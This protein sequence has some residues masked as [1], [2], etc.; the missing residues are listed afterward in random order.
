M[1]ALVSDTMKILKLMISIWSKKK[2]V[3]GLKEKGFC[4]A[5]TTCK[6]WKLPQRYAKQETV[7]EFMAKSEEFIHIWSICYFKY[8]EGPRARRELS[9]DCIIFP[10]LSRLRFSL[11]CSAFFFCCLVFFAA[12]FLVEN[13][14]FDETPSQILYVSCACMQEIMFMLSASSVLP[15]E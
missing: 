7:K 15:R 4:A 1:F 12:F 13:Y 5:K 10:L 8:D 3:S 11:S 6:L 14:S 2:D 9:V